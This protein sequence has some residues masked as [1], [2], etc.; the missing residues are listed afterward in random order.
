VFFWSTFFI[1]NVLFWSTYLPDRRNFVIDVFSWST[2]IS[3][4][5]VFLIDVRS[6]CLCVTLVFSL[7][8]QGVHT[9]NDFFWGLPYPFKGVRIIRVGQNRM[10]TPQRIWP[11]IWWC[12]CQKN[13][14]YTVNIRFWP[15]NHTY[16]VSCM[17]EALN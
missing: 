9:I 15:T 17:F 11:Y 8:R 3:D 12:P 1:I 13:R 2:Y 7:G 4:R 10:Y 14:T 16:Y 5:C 6:H